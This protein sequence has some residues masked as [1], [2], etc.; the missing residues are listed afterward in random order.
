VS[1]DFEAIGPYRVTGLLGRGGMG[2]VYSGTHAKNEQLVAIKVLSSSL[3]QHARFRRRFDAEI[4]TLLRLKHPNIVQLI[5]FGEEKGLLFYSMEL[6]EGENLH[7]LLKRESTVSWSQSM[8]W[9]IEICDALKHAH[10]FGIIHR[11]LK[12]A[13]LMINSAGSIK[14]TD[15]G[16]VKL[17]GASEATVAGSILGTADFMSPEQAEGKSVSVR[18]DLYALGAICYACLAGRPPFTGQSVPEIMFN[19]RYGNLTPLSQLAPKAPNEFCDLVM[20]LLNRDASRRPPTALAVGN[21]LKSMKAGLTNSIDTAPRNPSDVEHAKEMTSIDMSDYPSMARLSDAPENK[22]TRF[23][24]PE[25]PSP[26]PSSVP[27]RNRSYSD[28]TRFGNR[29]VAG[30]DDVTQAVASSDSVSSAHQDIPSGIEAMGKTHFTEVTDQDR[31]RTTV[32]LASPHEEPSGTPWASIATIG[33]LLACCLGLAYWLSRPPSATSLFQRIQATVVAENEDALL[34]AE[35]TVQRFLELYPEDTRASEIKETLDEIS[36]LKTL[37]RLQVR[38]GYRADKFDAQSID[39]IE[40]STIDCLRLASVD[41]KAAIKKIDALLLV[42]ASAEQL[43]PYQKRLI[44]ANRKLREQLQKNGLSSTPNHAANQLSQ[45]M[46][47]ADLNLNPEE[48]RLFLHGI[49]E[50]YSEKSWAKEIM[51]S[52]KLELEI[53]DK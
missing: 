39:P 31:R 25:Y 16:I 18:S 30:P 47:W 21:R 1:L 20:E 27:S 53:S 2:T 15:F 28:A 17:Y 13:N 22:A 10:N 36:I 19:V 51:D 5:G 14:L 35:P 8:D 41:P 50:L 44:D 38:S 26:P 12:P 52:V 49:V 33:T 48:R 32:S 11:D 34:E 42:F 45:Q 40:Q 7:Q 43:S 3:A 23:G 9:A 46:R 6:V 29:S 4:Q 37:R 24:D